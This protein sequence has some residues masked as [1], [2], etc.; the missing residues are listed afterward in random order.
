MYDYI[1]IIYYII[2]LHGNCNDNCL[3]GVAVSVCCCRSRGLRFIETLGLQK[4][5][6]TTRSLE[7]GSSPPC[8]RQHGK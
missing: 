3:I 4:C 5:L 7:L 2:Y 1:L 6:I 8:L